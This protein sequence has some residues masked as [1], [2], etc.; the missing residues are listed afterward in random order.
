MTQVAD[1]A[2]RRLGSA[3]AG[4]AVPV[5]LGTGCIRSDGDQDSLDDGLRQYR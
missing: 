1:E 4:L 5:V 2:A 3:G